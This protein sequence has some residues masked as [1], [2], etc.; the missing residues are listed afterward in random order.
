MG[1]GLLQPVNS[2]GEPPASQNHFNHW[3]CDVCDNIIPDRWP[4][5][6]LPSLLYV[7]IN[8]Y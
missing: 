1:W 3:L 2:S 4:Q 5:M 6:R 8:Q 7:S